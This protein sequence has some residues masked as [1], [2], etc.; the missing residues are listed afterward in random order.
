[1]NKNISVVGCGYW[2]K[3][4]IR[5]FHELGVLDSICDSDIT[6]AQEYANQFKVNIKSF[7][8]IKNDTKIKGVVLAVPAPLHASM[9]IEMMNFGKH[10]FVEKPLAMSEI[11]AEDMIKASKKN[12][13]KLMVG[14]LMQFHPVFKTILK[15]VNSGDLGQLKYIYSNRLSLGKVRT[16]EDIIWSFAPHDISMILSLTDQD[17][18]SIRTKSIQMIQKNISDSATIHI[19]FHSGLKSHIFVSWLH[20]FKEH[21]LV[22]IGESAMLVFDDVNTWSEKLSLYP[23]KIVSN[24]GLIDFNKSKFNYINVVEEE[25]LKNECKHFVDVVE[26]NI[27]PLTNCIEG[28]KVLK[29]L[30]A[31]SISQKKDEVIELK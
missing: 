8:E 9:A 26:K 18:K 7:N 10:V 30:N 6:S 16:E 25:P 23:Y 2:G 21:K 17:P 11:E 19:D 29:I 22:I 4:L 5:N 27:E 15:L 28:L 20:P 3:N 1:V 14:H 12:N 24:N 13:V 31:A